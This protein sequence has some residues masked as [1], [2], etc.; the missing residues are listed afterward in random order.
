VAEV[1]YQAAKGLRRYGIV[2]CF[3]AIGGHSLCSVVDPA[4]IGFKARGGKDLPPGK[5]NA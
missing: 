3:E 2:E 4:E 1:A 5:R